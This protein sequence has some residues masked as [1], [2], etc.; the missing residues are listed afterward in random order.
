VAGSVDGRAVVERVRVG[1]ELHAV[2]AGRCAVGSRDAAAQDRQRELK[3][4][5]LRVVGEVAG[6]QDGVRAL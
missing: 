1:G 2:V 3:L 4:V 5:G 6:H